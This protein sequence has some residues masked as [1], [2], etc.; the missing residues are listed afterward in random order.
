MLPFGEEAGRLQNTVATRRVGGSVSSRQGWQPVA[1]LVQ[2]EAPAL[3]AIFHPLAA[4]PPAQQQTPLRPQ[5]PRVRLGSYSLRVLISTPTASSEPSP[6]A[7]PSPRQP[8]PAP[9]LAP[10]QHPP[11]GGRSGR[12]KVG[13]LR[14]ALCP[15]P[16]T[17]GPRPADGDGEGREGVGGDAAARL[18]KVRTQGGGKRTL[19]MHKGRVSR[20][21][22]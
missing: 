8:P 9:G 14:G 18:G 17:L 20:R 1:S 2:A 11:W 22:A 13:S 15:V 21:C 7:P 3:P 10:R 5:V 4:S 12:G 6:A 16:G 19:R